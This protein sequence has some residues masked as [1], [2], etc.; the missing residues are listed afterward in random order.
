MGDALRPYTASAGTQPRQFGVTPP[1][2]TAAPTAA[3]LQLTEDLVASLRAED[4]FEPEDEARKRELVLAQLS[5]MFR[6]FVV[7]V[8]LR[9]GMPEAIAADAGG[10]IF[11]FGSYR[12]GVH[13]TGAD[14]DTLCVAP[15]HVTR[16]DFFADMFEA[17]QARADVTELAAVPDAYVPVIKFKF[18]DIPIDLVFAR[19]CLPAVPDDLVLLDDALLKGLDERDVRSVNGS[20]VTDEILRLVPN[21]GAFRLALRCV[22]LW[23]K[24]RAVYSNVLGFLGG[25]AW[26]MLVA[27]VCQLYPNACAATLVGKFFRIMHQ[28][29]VSPARARVADSDRG[30]AG[31]GRSPCC[32]SPS[33]TARCRCA[34]GTPSCTPPTARTACPSSRPRTPACAPRT[35]SRQARRPS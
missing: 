14:I 12:L 20:R 27:R 4:Q 21:M 28:W 8:S 30:A 32:S 10:K 2:S 23:A 22:K 15:K 13:G 19:L 1:I 11:T 3:D 6:A 17:L 18:A 7:A 24:R 5:A 33:R 26:A 34:C 16:D 29:C 31:T 9:R 35:T 25:V